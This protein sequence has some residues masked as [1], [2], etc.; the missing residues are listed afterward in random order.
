MLGLHCV[1]ADYQRA[2]EIALKKRG[3]QFQREVEVPVVYKGEFVTRRRVDFVVWRD[4]QELILATKARAALLPEDVEQCL[5]YLKQGGYHICLLVNFGQKPIGVKRLVDWPHGAPRG[6]ASARQ[7][8]AAPIVF[9]AFRVRF[10]V[11]RDPKRRSRLSRSK[12]WVAS[13]A[14]Q[15]PG[16]GRKRL[17]RSKGWLAGVGNPTSGPSWPGLRIE[18]AIRPW[19]ADRAGGQ[20][21]PRDP[22]RRTDQART[23]VPGG[24]PPDDVRLGRHDRI[25]GWSAS[26]AATMPA[27]HAMATATS[28]P[29]GDALVVDYQGGWCHPA[30]KPG[31]SHCLQPWPGPFIQSDRL[32]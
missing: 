24:A 21:H 9:R 13:L 20:D 14:I 32:R 4:D 29:T 3:L 28:G 27:S 2:L 1:E 17:S 12:A 11:S 10:R 31:P 7:P 19:T 26:G 23:R 22:L 18:T 25:A 30:V 5:L 16:R 15:S 6:E 8:W